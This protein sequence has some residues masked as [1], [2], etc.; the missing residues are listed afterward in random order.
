MQVC[1]TAIPARYPET[2]LSALRVS[3]LHPSVSSHCTILPTALVSSSQRMCQG[4][5]TPTAHTRLRH[6]ATACAAAVQQHNA[7]ACP[8]A[9]CWSA[10]A[11]PEAVQVIGELQLAPSSSA[12]RLTDDC[13]ICRAR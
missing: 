10:G 9:C 7:V 13:V 12:R 5:S 11:L 6:S 1:C 4:P 8:I 2:R 3:R